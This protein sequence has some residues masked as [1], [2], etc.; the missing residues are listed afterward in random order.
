MRDGQ[1]KPYV[2]TLCR[3]PE[4]Q[5]KSREEASQGDWKLYKTKYVN[6]LVTLNCI[7]V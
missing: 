7:S 5:N 6:S 4:K 3:E 2:G 1:V